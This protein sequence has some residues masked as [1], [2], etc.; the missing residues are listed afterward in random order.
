MLKQVCE[1][2]C[3]SFFLPHFSL[4]LTPLLYDACMNQTP[5]KRVSKIRNK[6][7]TLTQGTEEKV[8]EV[9]PQILAAVLNEKEYFQQNNTVFTQSFVTPRNAKLIAE[10][11]INFTPVDSRE[12]LYGTLGGKSVKKKREK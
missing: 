12:R 5:H 6:T 1:I 4:K 8:R 7:P 11:E 9:A 2:S 10:G 3:L